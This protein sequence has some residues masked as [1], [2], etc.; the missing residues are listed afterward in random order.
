MIPSQVLCPNRIRFSAADGF[1][2]GH[3][4]RVD[5]MWFVFPYTSLYE[6]RKM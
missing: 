2:G 1:D 5:G 6:E 4:P 3:D